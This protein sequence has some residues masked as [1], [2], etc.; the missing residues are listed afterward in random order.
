MRIAFA[1]VPMLVLAAPVAAQPPAAPP[2]QL[3]DPATADKLANAMQALSKA[4]LDLPVG[5]VQAAID[6]RAPTPADR[7]LTVRELGRRSDRNFDRDLQRQLANARPMIEQTMKALSDA[8]PGIMNGLAQARE[9]LDRAVANMP[10]PT[11][12]KR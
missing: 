1:L 11:Y 7:R 12:P 2:P 4:L 10:N 3:T 9:S 6:G 8:I 5:E